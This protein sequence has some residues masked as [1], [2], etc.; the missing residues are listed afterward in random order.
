MRLPF[1]KK[2]KIEDPTGWGEQGAP[3]P[4]PEP[5]APKIRTLNMPSIE[6][7]RLNLGKVRIPGLLG[8]KRVFAAIM[9]VVNFACFLAIAPIQDGIGI[10]FLI[11]SLYLLDYL[12][13]TRRKFVKINLTG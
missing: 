4:D 13:K 11:N 7:P 1:Q 6:I 10:F 12:Y 5:Q 3:Q 9:L 8:I 2:K